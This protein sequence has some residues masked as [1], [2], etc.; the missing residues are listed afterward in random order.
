MD[1]NAAELEPTELKLK[2][3]RSMG[4]N[5]DEPNHPPYGNE[6]EI[7]EAPEMGSEYLKIS[8]TLQMDASKEYDTPN[9]DNTLHPNVSLIFDMFNPY[10]VETVPA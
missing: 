1:I 2:Y 5:P 9:I 3:S 4:I 7:F 8:K 10:L 6:D